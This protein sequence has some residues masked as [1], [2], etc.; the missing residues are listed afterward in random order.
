MQLNDR[1]EKEIRA[2][3]SEIRYYNHYGKRDMIIRNMVAIK[4]TSVC[5]LLLTIAFFIVSW[6]SLKWDITWHFWLMFVLFAATAFFSVFADKRKKKE[7]FSSQILGSLF[8]IILAILLV[9]LGVF[10]NPEQPSSLL[11][12]FL[13]VLPIFFTAP[14]WI[15]S[16]ITITAGTA[17][18]ILASAYK[19][20]DIVSY[21]VFSTVLSMALSIVVLTYFARLRAVSF[22]AKEKYKRQSRMDLLTGVLNKRSFEL[23]CQKLLEE[24]NIDEPCA[25][26]IFDLDNFKHINDTFGHIIGDKVLEI[27]GQTLSENFRADGLAGRIGGDEF[28]AFACT[29]EGCEFFDRR[30]ESV[31]S[32]VKERSYNL[33]KIEATMSVG[34]AK[35]QFGGVSYLKMFLNADQVMYDSKRSLQYERQAVDERQTVSV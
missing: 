26:A 4:V 12:V 9:I 33:L 3:V 22:I 21:D 10:Y 25:L 35:V 30:A 6:I 2:H 29:R 16:T 17:F 7:F 28:S 11:S 8:H 32:E 20:P 23:W 27:V 15:V 18:C 19:A 5:S 13:I 1:L 34:T 14:T 31:I 24:R